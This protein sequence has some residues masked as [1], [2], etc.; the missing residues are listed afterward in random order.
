MKQVFIIHGTD[1]HPAENWFPW[2]KLQLENLGYSVVV[3]QFPVGALQTPEN[4]HIELN[5]YKNRF[6]YETIIIGHSF[7]AGFLLKVL[8]QLENR[9]RAAVF[10]SPPVGVKP[11]KYWELD[12]PLLKDGFEW[13]RIKRGAKHHIVF[14]SED[15]PYISIGNGEKVAQELAIKLQK[16]EFAGHFN[17]ASGY[18]K[19][20]RLLETLKPIL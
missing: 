9:I 17:A 5:K 3:P 19:F 2:L 4:W 1:G 20:T 10:I 12:K 13:S 15:D 18:T 11:I 14:H 7:G 16:E 6:D 8:E